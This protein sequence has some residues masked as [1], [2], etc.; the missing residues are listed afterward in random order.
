[1]INQVSA[2]YRSTEESILINH[3]K[4]PTSCPIWRSN[5]KQNASVKLRLRYRKW[6]LSERANHDRNTKQQ[7]SK[8][9]A[10]IMHE[11]IRA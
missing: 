3:E 4:I 10:K 5:Q 6:I 8:E 7:N 1:M 2:Q 11:T 9:L